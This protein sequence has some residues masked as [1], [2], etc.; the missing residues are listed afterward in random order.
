MQKETSMN[1]EKKLVNISRKSFV[2]VLILLAVL[3]AVSILLTYVIPKGAYRTTV[4][5]GKEVTDYQSYISLPDASG[6]PVWKGIASP[7]LILGSS[8]GLNIIMLSLFLLV[9]VGTFQAMNDN[10]GVKV[11]IGRVTSR[12]HGHRFLLV[13]IVS[14][15]FMLFGALFGLFE[16]MLTLLP[17]IAALTISLGYDS[18]TGFLVSIGAVGF[19]FS[20]AIT[21]PF[22]VLFAS[23]IIGVN[24]M[25]N[26]WFRIVIF[27]VMYGLVEA[28]IYLYTKRIVKKP[29]NSFTYAH[30]LRMKE[31]TVREET[32]PNEKR[33]FYS[34]LIFFVIVLAVLI[35]FSSVDAIRGYTVPALIGVFLIGG[36]AASFSASGFKVKETL[37]SFLNG[38][39]SALPT[40]L[41]ILMAS[42]IK[43]ILVEGNVLPTITNTI[44]GAVQNRNP[45]S[46]ALLLFLIVLVLEFFISSSTAKAVFVMS[47][48]SVLTIS[49]TKEMQV[50]IY[51][52]ADG[53]ANLL[54]PTSPVLLIG[55]SMI[56][57]SYFKWLKKMWPMFLITFS[58][59]IVFLM[60]GVLCGY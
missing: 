51:T 60:L 2:S 46:L 9:I 25:T 21:N 22:T 1:P 13:S 42:S 39:L 20:S 8:D 57:F 7:V 19:G 5:D 6:I 10:S 36:T 34:Y 29:E 18:F 35:T 54:F 14:L 23:E 32:I 3:M 26:I 56:D 49:L 40:I 28:V 50:L 11:I 53:Y 38:V 37:K 48:L 12:F 27:I 31:L 4:V 24:P 15:L 17:I 45:Y 59:V 47:V 52:L 55:L 30:D 44:N 16:E 58:L 41:F 43:Y 33:V